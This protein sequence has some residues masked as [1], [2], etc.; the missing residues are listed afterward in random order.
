MLARVGT[1]RDGFMVRWN[2]LGAVTG[3]AIFYA[4]AS[5]FAL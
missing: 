3:D 2:A 4:L 1:V 5:V